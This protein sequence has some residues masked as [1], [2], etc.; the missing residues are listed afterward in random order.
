MK[1]CPQG[2]NVKLH[3]IFLYLFLNICF[4]LGW[5]DS[6]EK[7]MTTCSSNL[8]WEIPEREK[9]GRFM[10]VHVSTRVTRVWHN[11][12]TKL[13]PTSFPISKPKMDFPQGSYLLS[14]Y[15]SVSTNE[16][17]LK[18]LC[19]RPSEGKEYKDQTY[20]LHIYNLMLHILFEHWLNAKQ[21]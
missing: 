18:W 10:W 3:W 9:P 15:R 7:E 1:I 14:S 12:T 13:P 4:C 21:W 16:T 19:P 5:E 11:L 8:A 20:S 17:K 6:L 2:F